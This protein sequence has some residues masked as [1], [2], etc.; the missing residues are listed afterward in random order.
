MARGLF[1]IPGVAPVTASL[2]AATVGD[3]VRRF[4]RGRQLAAWLGL[5][6]RQYSSGG[7]T[8]VRRITKAGHREIRRLLVLGATSMTYRAGVWRGVA[9]TRVQELLERRSVRHVT[10]VLADKT[11]RIA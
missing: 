7:R 2:I 4:A 3:G 6:A 9:G 8:Q 10:V 1:T 5:V 11:V